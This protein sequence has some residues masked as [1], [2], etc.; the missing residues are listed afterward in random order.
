MDESIKRLLGLRKKTSWIFELWYRLRKQLTPK[1]MIVTALLFMF[2][3]AII[4]F[5]RIE[6]IQRPD[7]MQK[8]AETGLNPY[9]VSLYWLITTI[10]TVGYGDITPVTMQGKMLALLI[11]ILGIVSVSLLISQITSRIVAINLG[12]MFGVTRTRK[13]IDCILCGWN[14][15]SEAALDEINA[16]G[17]EVVIIDKLNRPD[18]A[19]SKDVHFMV[20]NPTSPD[21]LKRANVTNAKNIVLAMDEDSDV[22]LAI[23]VIRELNPWIN[24]VAKINNHEHIKIAESAGADQVVSPPSIG[25]R[26]LSMVADEPSAVEWLTRATSKA[27]GVRLMEYDVT[28]ESPFVNKTLAEIRSM[29]KDTAKI[30]GVDTPEGLE[31]I[32]GDDLKIEQGNKLIMLI[33][34]KRF[35]L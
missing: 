7:V 31:K 26:L 29:V 35:K 33:D 17:V 5:A 13:K 14:P 16:P 12:S 23:H 4:L 22:L 27:M 15:T 21:V 24:I 11:M 9:F 8:F 19:K 3:A 28:E 30:I 25:G 34:V 32:P 10:T 6:L 18:L 1:L 20:G 2:I